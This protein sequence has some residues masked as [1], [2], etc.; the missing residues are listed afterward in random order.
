[1]V[2]AKLGRF[3]FAAGRVLPEI[4]GT[5]AAVDEIHIAGLNGWLGAV[6]AMSTGGD[7][8]PSSWVGV[9][10]SVVTSWLGSDHIY[11]DSK[12]AAFTGIS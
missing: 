12:N 3:N 2:R 4:L 10:M 1:V 7:A 5:F 9:L 11:L 8:V 6:S